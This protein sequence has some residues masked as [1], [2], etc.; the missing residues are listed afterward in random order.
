MGGFPPLRDGELLLGKFP[1][2]TSES[3]EFSYELL[4]GYDPAL[5]LCGRGKNTGWGAPPKENS[6]T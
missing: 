5:V 1:S 4:F 3:V 6:L 2:T